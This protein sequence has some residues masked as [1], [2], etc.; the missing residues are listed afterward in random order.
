[1]LEE[2]DQVRRQRQQNK[3]KKCVI[4][5]STSVE[6]L[7]MLLTN[8]SSDEDVCLSQEDECVQPGKETLL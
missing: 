2:E 4:S 3:Q 8:F 7:A 5:Q 1:M 6:D